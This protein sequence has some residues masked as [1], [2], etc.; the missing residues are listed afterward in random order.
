MET[1]MDLTELFLENK[2]MLIASLAGAAG[3]LFVVAVP[4][5]AFGL[6]IYRSIRQE[7]LKP[8][9]ILK[10]SG[11]QFVVTGRPPA[12]KGG[13][14]TLAWLYPYDQVPTVE[15]YEDAISLVDLKAVR[16]ERQ[17]RLSNRHWVKGERP[18]MKLRES[19]PLWSGAVLYVAIGVYLILMFRGILS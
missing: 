3:V 9:D 11:Q 7:Y 13:G 19:L 18:K 12:Q 2:D 15:H 17:V 4:M 16:S 14:A 1:G 6:M 8:G 10:I 5:V